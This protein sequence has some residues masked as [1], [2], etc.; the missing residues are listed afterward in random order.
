MLLHTSR[1]HRTSIEM[2]DW[3]LGQQ[4][5]FYNRIKGSP[6][7]TWRDPILK[8]CISGKIKHLSNSQWE[9]ERLS[10]YNYCHPVTWEPFISSQWETEWE[11]ERETLR[12]EEEMEEGQGA[13]R[14]VSWQ[15][16]KRSRRSEKQWAEPDTHTQMDCTQNTQHMHNS[17]V[18]LCPQYMQVCVHTQ[19]HSFSSSVWGFVEL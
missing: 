16:S 13:D 4:C 9:K 10:S 18:K 14:L 3:N 5:P 7:T 6:S 19:E 1:L 17:A 2:S 8:G 11:R 12:E 15:G